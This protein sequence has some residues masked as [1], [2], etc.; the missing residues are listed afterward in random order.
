MEPTTLAQKDTI[1]TVEPLKTV[2]ELAQ[3]LVDEKKIK[4]EK[5]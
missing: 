2:M 4:L 1:D 5:K 3:L